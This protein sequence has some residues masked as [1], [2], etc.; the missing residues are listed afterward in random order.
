MAKVICDIFL[1]FYDQN[2]NCPY[3]LKMAKEYKKNRPEFDRK[4]IENGLENMV[5][6]I[7]LSN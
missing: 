6:W 2:P 1:L 7:M 3:D 4:A 5:V